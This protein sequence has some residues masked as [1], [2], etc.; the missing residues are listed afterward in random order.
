MNIYVSFKLVLQL[1]STLLSSFLCFVFH[2]VFFDNSD[3][4]FLNYTWNEPKLQASLKNAGDRK[5][6]VFVG[7]D[8]FGRN[9]FGGGG[10]NT[11]KVRKFVQRG[12]GY[13]TGCLKDSRGRGCS[14]HALTPP[15]VLEKGTALMNSH[16]ICTGTI[17]KLKFL[18]KSKL[19][20]PVTY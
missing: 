8:V 1:L 12:K 19:I 17:F 11:N 13:N 3:G 7:V 14:A 10:W 16:W 18:A 4:I 6:D 20:F 15:A 2:R 5:N 9:C